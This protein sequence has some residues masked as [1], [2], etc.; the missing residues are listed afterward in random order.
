MHA[1]DDVCQ[2]ACVHEEAVDGARQAML[3]HDEAA[4]LAEVFKILGDPT[5]VRLLSGLAQ[6][7]LCVCDLSVLLD[8]SQSAVSH[9]LRV[10]RA[11]RMVKPRR[12]GKMVFYFL[13]D[14]HVERLFAQALEHVRE[15]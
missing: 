7:E 13:D 10:L 3:G 6:G 2:V 9:Q 5:R 12:Q 15:G 1:Q 11:A 8:M 14:E 4:S